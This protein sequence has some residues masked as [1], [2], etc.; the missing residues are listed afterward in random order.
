VLLWSESARVVDPKDFQ[1]YTWADW[2]K[3]G[4]GNGDDCICA[5][6]F[7][8]RVPEAVALCDYDRLPVAQVAFSRWKVFKR[9]VKNRVKVLT[10]SPLDCRLEPVCQ[11]L[12]CPSNKGLS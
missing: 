2:P 10:E 3:L 11:E 8:L 9:I 12:N 7:K 1:F 6:R 5:V 4:A